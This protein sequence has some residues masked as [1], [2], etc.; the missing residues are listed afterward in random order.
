MIKI[1]RHFRVWLAP[2]AVS[3]VAVG[4]AVPA[5]AQP[6]APS[7]AVGTPVATT[8]PLQSL[9]GR[10][11]AG[12]K[13]WI[14]NDP[15]AYGQA[16][17]SKR[18]VRTPSGLSYTGCVFHVPD[19]A[20]VTNGLIRLPSGATH[21][22]KPCEYPTLTYPGPA[23]T[24]ATEPS[25]TEP[26][27]GQTVPGTGPCYFGSSTR[28]WALSCY[29][30]DPSW[31][32]SM[33]QEYAV[34]TDPAKS[35]ALLF[36]WGGAENGSNGTLLQ[37]VLTWGANGN[38]VTN[39]NIWYVTPWYLW[40]NNSVTGASIH[41]GPLD[42]IVAGLTASDCN[43]SGDCTWVLSSTDTTN[44]RSTSYTV[45]S[46]SSFDMLLGAVMEIP[47]ADGCDETPANGHMAFRD[48]VVTGSN[49]PITPDFGTSIADPQ[50]SVSMTQSAT[51]ADILWKP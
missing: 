20:T 42:T 24:T 25:T 22:M 1:R 5:Q 17:K 41:V 6:A 44:G 3:A 19:H 39:P 51:G 10:A 37:D 14:V 50:C 13:R 26:G 11:P 46:D 21:Q 47:T 40:A 9:V 23:K 2:V 45:N 18:W 12:G 36:F 48:L 7:R 29:G 8:Q 28:F 32:T 31:M 4:L 35:G 38:I 34:P 27:S 49:G 43:S 30:T 15:A 16:V 33:T